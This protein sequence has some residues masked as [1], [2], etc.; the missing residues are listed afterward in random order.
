M[1]SNDSD[2]NSKLNLDSMRDDLEAM[3]LS[4]Y[5]DVMNDSK[6]DARTRSDAADKV[7]KMLGKDAPA[8]ASGTSGPQ[9]GM[10]IQFGAALKDSLNGIALLTKDA[11]QVD[12]TGGCAAQVLPDEE[13][14]K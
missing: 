11:G 5:I 1:K 6:V 13:P 7:M 2:E 3:A 8:K 14:L 9:V 4:V 12:L 10:V